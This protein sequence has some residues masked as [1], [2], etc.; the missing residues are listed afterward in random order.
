MPRKSR[1]P[2]KRESARRVPSEHRVAARTG[3]HPRA[4]SRRS[5]HR[6]DNVLFALA[7]AGI[8]LTSYLTLIAW[9]GEKPAFCGADSNCDLVQQSRW[10]TLLGMPLALWGLFTYALLAFLLWRMRSHPNAWRTALL[11]AVVGAAVSW[12]LTAISTFAIE[13]FCAYCVASFILLNILLVLLLLRRPA[14]ISAHAWPRA[15]PGPLGAAAVIVLGL[16]MHFGGVFDR[17]AGPEQPYLKALAIHLNTSGARFYGAYWC[18]TC[19]KQKDL[20]EASAGRLPYVECTPEGRGGIVNF[21]CVANNVNDYP[22]W[23]IGGQRRTGLVSP[24]ELASLSGFVWS[25]GTDGKK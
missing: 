12:Y 10:S 19:Q 4:A 18:P 21:A 2:A 3:E 13:A 11:V 8:A 9:F 16:V 17:A 14:Q 23:I 25:T 7:L 20:F 22:T 15:L 1:R 24:D 6:L 5:P